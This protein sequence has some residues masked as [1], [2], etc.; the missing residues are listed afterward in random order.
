LNLFFQILNCC[1]TK[2]YQLKTDDVLTK[3]TSEELIFSLL[4]TEQKTLL[5][6]NR[7]IDV[8]YALLGYR[9]RV[10]CYYAKSTL[11]AC[12]RIIPPVIKS[13]DE[14]NLPSQFHTFSQFHDGLVLICGPTGEGKTTSLAAIVN[15]I[16]LEET[17][18]IVTVEDPIE[19]VFP[20]AKSIV[21]QREL[22]YDTHS[23]TKALTSVL[24]EDPDVVLIGEMRDYDTIQAALNI[25]ETGHLVFSTLH[26]STTPEAIF[27]I[28]DVFPPHQQTQ[29]RYQLAS[30]LKAAITQRLLPNIN[31]STRIPAVEIL[32][33][34]PAVS[35]II[36]EG[37][38]FML[39]NV[40]ET[41]EENKMILFEKYLL[42]LYSQG[43]I[44]RDT[45][46]RYAERSSELS[47]FIK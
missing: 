7:E 24:R 10:N 4:T 6:N 15:E 28:I 34:M 35:S 13:I 27:R 25:A 20:K 45:A 33:N 41:N 39:D 26:S 9:F 37:K 30:V 21:S 3:E 36:R 42:K 8:S 44:S 12:F 47:K 22:H 18:H 14:L 31:N 2:L 5:I 11:A 17:K 46:I 23:W 43:L 32:I 19:Y 29:V 1:H 16:N 40:I 38:I